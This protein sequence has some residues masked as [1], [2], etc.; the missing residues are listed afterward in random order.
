MIFFYGT[1]FYIVHCD[2]LTP[3][4]RMQGFYVLLFGLCLRALF[5]STIA[6]RRLY[7]TLSTV[8]FLMA[9]VICICETWLLVRQAIRLFRPLKTGDWDGLRNYLKRD[10]G[11][12]ALEYVPFVCYQ[13]T[14]PQ[15][16]RTGR[17]WKLHLSS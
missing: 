13:L 12:T 7:I 1:M 9:T 14:D 6:T 16:K 17:L 4:Q 5:R 11:K 3:D 10:S 8:L 15:L 2:K